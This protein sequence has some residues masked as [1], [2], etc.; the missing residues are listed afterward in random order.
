MTSPKYDPSSP[1]LT[2][3]TELHPKFASLHP[4]TEVRSEFSTVLT[5]LTELHPKFAG[6]HPPHPTTIQFSTVLTYLTEL[7][8]EL[9]WTI[10]G[11]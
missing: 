9:A 7:R 6:V 2:H 8:S 5:H 1:P 4:L 11:A 10:I 3:L